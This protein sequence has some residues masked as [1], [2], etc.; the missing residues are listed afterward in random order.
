MEKTLRQKQKEEAIKRMKLLQI[1]PQVREDFKSNDT[2]YY[3]ERQNSFFNA[4]LYWLRNHPEYVKL[5]KELEEENGALVYHAQ[6]THTELGDMLSLL[7]VSKN[8]EEWEMDKDDIVNGQAFVRVVNLDDDLLSD[9][10]TIGIKPSMGG[11]LR[12]W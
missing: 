3:S 12:T 2:I 9:F 10:G 7:Y 1:M 6:L 11:V 4:T 5:A 8:E